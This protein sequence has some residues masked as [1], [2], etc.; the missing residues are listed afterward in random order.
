MGPLVS[1]IAA[2]SR[3][4]PRPSGILNP[5]LVAMLPEIAEL[6]RWL[7]A[8]RAERDREWRAAGGLR[9][10]E[11]GYDARLQWEIRERLEANRA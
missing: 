5:A 3:A 4:D 7:A 8:D 2:A 11:Q 1:R 9:P 10:D 6:K